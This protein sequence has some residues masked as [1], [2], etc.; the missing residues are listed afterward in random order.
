V[1]WHCHVLPAALVALIVGI[2]IG[3]DGTLEGWAVSWRS[4]RESA[5]LPLVTHML[6]HGG[7]THVL[8]NGAALL[9]L[10]GPIISRLGSPPVSWLRYMYIIVGS[11]I[12]GAVL[13]LVLSRGE[14][15][16]LGASGAVFGLVGTLAR[17]HPSTGNAVPI[18]SHRTW[19]VLKFFFQNHLLLFFLLVIVAVL[20]GESA[21]VAWEA[22]F[23]GL[24]FGFFVAP[25]F[26]RRALGNREISGC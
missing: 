7:W 1:P 24:L 4:V 5:V 16:M 13:F 22:H 15:S 2:W 26:L 11:A 9:L 3:S 17:I 20:T 18:R 10:S 21:F 12:S 14:T 6:T 23:G 8:L 25:L 19:A